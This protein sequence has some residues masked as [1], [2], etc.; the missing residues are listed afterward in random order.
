M[1]KNKILR[2]ELY[3]LFLLTFFS[4]LYFYFQDVFPD[5]FLSISSDNQSANFFTYYPSSF[6]AFIGNYSGI[7]I[8]LPFLT[9]SLSYAFLFQKRKKYLDVLAFFTYS[10]F[11]VTLAY[12]FF[13]S[14]LGE[15]LHTILSDKLNLYFS[16][17][18]SI[19]FLN[20]SLYL[21]FG[22]AYVEFLT[23][24][25]EKIKSTFIQLK[26][27]AEKVG[28]QATELKTNLEPKAKSM[29]AL[30]LE[31]WNAYRTKSQSEATEE[32]L[33]NTV[34]RETVAEKP[35]EPTSIPKLQ[36][37]VEVASE[38]EETEIETEEE[39]EELELIEEEDFESEDEVED[40]NTDT[41]TI[42]KAKNKTQYFEA[43]DL[44][45]SISISR[46]RISNQ[47]ENAY[48]D[49]KIRRLEEKMKEFK[50]NARVI[51]VLKG[52]VVDT[53]EIELGSGVKI[54]S[55]ISLQN[56][57]SLALSGVPIRM[58]YPMKGR[59]TLG[60]EIPRNP[61]D[62]IYLD[63]LLKAKSFTDTRAKL[64]VVM[65]KNAIGE[66][67]IV[68]LA[69]MPHMLVAGSTGAGKS[70]FV[71]TL[72]FS[73]LV[74]L[75]PDQMKL[76]LIDPKQLEL[77][78]YS[79]LPHLM[80]PVITEPKNVSMALSWACEEMERRYSI[81]KELAVKNIDGFNQKIKTCPDEQ[82]EK[83]AKYYTEEDDDY[84]LP[85]LV[86]VVDEFADLVLSRFG[87]DIE[88]YIARLAAKA[89]AAGIHI[90]LATQRPSVDVIT[91]VIKNNFPS[92]VA[93]KVQ[94]PQD[95]RTILNQIGAENL[96]GKGDMLFSYN[97]EISRIHSAYVDE[98]EIEVLADKL[99]KI[100][101]KFNQKA[102]DYIENGGNADGEGSSE[103]SL[104]GD[105]DVEDSL[106]REAIQIIYENRSRGA[107]TSF[108]QRKLK[109][110][111]N[112]AANLIDAME[113]KGIIGPQ[114][115]GSKTRPVLPAIENY[116]Q[117]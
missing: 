17:L 67:T 36:P 81:L 25:Y 103:G 66:P 104:S 44:I 108:L 6:V 46:D 61:R 73:L 18:L 48:F 91:G 96:L 69:S 99:S 76:I 21:C 78:L 84:E 72:L 37:K 92:R 59:T 19:I 116:L 86:I 7:W 24:V 28:T 93:F 115:P 54:S 53:F 1:N 88:G 9:L 57:L 29:Y 113:S 94:G 85:Y 22:N 87:K 95:S 101:A 38:T 11:F 32:T 2:F 35:A 89:R 62:V 14:L 60:I 30:I 5:T 15:G 100:P 77:A 47:P 97:S 16:F 105:F 109:L 70:V 82:L 90:V 114:V 43:N 10:V 23:L 12:T 49:E 51:N 55:I 75:S 34:V 42:I 102:L 56:D 80:L 4:A 112:R 83:I 63:D 110:G 31:K 45:D 40:S 107:S 20:L 65:G 111:F 71:N 106:F 98:T 79:T 74:K 3:F 41:K 50:I 33:N 8:A 26:P 13:P 68:D 58:V 39:V 52:P 64:P 27:I 117:D